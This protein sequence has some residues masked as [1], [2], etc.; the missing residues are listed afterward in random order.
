MRVPQDQCLFLTVLFSIGLAATLIF[1]VFLPVHFE[2]EWEWEEIEEV[3]L[4]TL[5][6]SVSPEERIV[7]MQQAIA[8]AEATIAQAEEEA[9]T[10]ENEAA[11]EGAEAAPEDVKKGEGE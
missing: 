6:K 9:A 2:G 11:G 3:E 5:P 7:K 4:L 8:F 10:E 1:W